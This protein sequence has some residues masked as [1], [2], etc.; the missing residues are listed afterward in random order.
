MAIYE[1][2]VAWWTVEIDF[3]EVYASNGT[4]AMREN[5]TRIGA[6]CWISFPTDLLELEFGKQAYNCLN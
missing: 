4:V 6:A 3:R 2:I 5:V 1:I